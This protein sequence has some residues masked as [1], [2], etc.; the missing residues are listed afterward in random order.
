M[1][2]ITKLFGIIAIIAIIGIAVMITGCG[3]K[4]GTVTF[5]ND[6][7]VPFEIIISV[8]SSGSNSFFIKETVQ[9]GNQLSRSLDEDG[10]YYITGSF[11][12]GMIEKTINR[13][14]TL[15]GGETITIRASEF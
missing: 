12:D 1:K 2:N 8:A 13:D 3:Q 14:G 15:S 9:P 7:T 6:V 10:Y 5:I 4:G 11:M